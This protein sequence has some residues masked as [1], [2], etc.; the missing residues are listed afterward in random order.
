[1]PTSSAAT[2]VVRLGFLDLVREL[3][4]WV[5][6]CSAATRV[7]R[8]GFFD[9]VLELVLWVPTSSAATRVVRLSG[10]GTSV[11]GAHLLSSNS[12]S[13]TRFP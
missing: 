13:Q 6:T 9:L 7:V 10:T 8:L 3:V 5:P 2:R 4:L 12:C 1:M 11:V